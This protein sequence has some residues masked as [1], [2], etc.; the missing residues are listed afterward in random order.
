M[1]QDNDY[2]EAGQYV[3]I[4]MLSLSLVA[5]VSCIVTSFEIYAQ[6]FKVSVATDIEERS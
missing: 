2:N 5:C 6:T 3:A 4:I 1:L